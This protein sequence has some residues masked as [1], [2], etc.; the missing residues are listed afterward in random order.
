[1]KRV[2]EEVYVEPQMRGPT[3][4]SRGE[5]NGRPSTISG[6]GTTGG[7]TTVD[8]LTYLKAVKDMFQDNKE[9][10]ETFLGVM[11]DFKAQRVDTN[12]V[13]ARVKD[14]FK[15]YDDLLLGFN[16]FL[17]KGYKITLQP[18]DEKPKKPVDF[19]VAI[20]FVNRIKV[21]I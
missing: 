3:V 2:R 11:K 7:L 12:G 1:M 5:T 14:L 13:I 18:E 6:G 4:S 19:Q 17:P 20:E 21:C 10:Y 15:G 8:A 9:K 16:T